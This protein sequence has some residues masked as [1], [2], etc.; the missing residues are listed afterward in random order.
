LSPEV[1]LSDASQKKPFSPGR[2]Q[3]SLLGS[4]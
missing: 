1:I 3:R 2:V 4:F